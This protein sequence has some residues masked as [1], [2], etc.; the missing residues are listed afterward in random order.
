MQKSLDY[1]S[2]YIFYI[3][4]IDNKAATIDYFVD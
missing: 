3:Y 4:I 2:D 1:V